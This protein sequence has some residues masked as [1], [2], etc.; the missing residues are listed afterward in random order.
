MED[1][2]TETVKSEQVMEKTVTQ[3]Q[4]DM[5]SGVNLIVNIQPLPH[6]DGGRP[7]PPGTEF[8]RKVFQPI[9]AYATKTIYHKAENTYGESAQQIEWFSDDFVAMNLGTLFEIPKR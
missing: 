6:R 8:R 5:I 9:V 1:I 2:L 3:E 4:R 7:I